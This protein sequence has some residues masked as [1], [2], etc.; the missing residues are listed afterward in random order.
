MPPR[1]DKIDSAPILVSPPASVTET[2]IMPDLFDS[3]DDWAE[4]AAEL[5][6]DKPP[7]PPA[8]P[9]D[10]VKSL[11]DAEDVE[12]HQED[13][14]AEEEAVAEGEPEAAAEEEFDDAEDA[15]GGEAAE[16]EAPGTGKKRRRRRRRRRKGG[17]AEPAAATPTEGEAEAEPVEE[18]APEAA[19]E[20]EADDF[21]E[22]VATDAE[23]EPLPFGA[24]EDTASEVLR[25]LIASW[26]VPSWDDIVGGL[27][28]PN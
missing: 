16:G 9:A 7:P 28:R 14:R 3:N 1:R 25:E 6:R 23:S 13:P 10:R 27:Y 20:P 11:F 17:P 24:E 5:A 18:P 22:G 2:P 26:N 19:A 15:P 8:P 12:S 21:G 4:L